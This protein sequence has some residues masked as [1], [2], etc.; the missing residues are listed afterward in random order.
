MNKKINA[1]LVGVSFALAAC[2]GGSDKSG[3]D[4]ERYENS[5][6]IAPIPT[7]EQKLTDDVSAMT[8]DPATD[9]LTIG[10]DPF[11]LAGTFERVPQKD[12]RGFAAFENKTGARRYTALVQTDTANGLAAGVVG[13]PFRLDRE[14]G[15]TMLARSRTPTM[16][17]NVELTHVGDYAGV[18][19]VG[20]NNGADTSESFLHRVEGKVRLDLDFF[21]DR[22]MGAVEGVIYDRR[23]MDETEVVDE[24]SQN[25]AYDDVVLVFT[26]IDAA[27]NF[28]G[29]ATGGTYTGI[30]AGDDAAASAGVVDL[31]VERGAFIAR[32]K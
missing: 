12:V 15:G 1:T 19:N 10:G 30:I 26:D 31:G 24:K 27:G 25:V 20:T 3:P 11:D 7:A 29:T 4:G 32:T 6:K 16:P 28:S 2:G 5:G 9:T 17:T 8:Y 22:P 14:F 23:S 21:D 13:T 18:R